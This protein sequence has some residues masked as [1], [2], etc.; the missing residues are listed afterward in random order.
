MQ[1]TGSGIYT[2]RLEADENQPLASTLAPQL[3]ATLLKMSN[4]AA[5]KGLAERA[6][7]SLAGFANALSLTYE[8]FELR[9][10]FAP[11]PGLAD[12]G[13]LE[14][15]LADLLETVGEAAKADQGCVVLG[16]D[17]FQY[18]NTGET[19]ALISALHRISRLSLPVILIAAGLPQIRGNVGIAKSY[20]ERLFEF[21][22]IGQLG[23][24]DA[25]SAIAKP[26]QNEGQ[27]IEPS[28]LID[29]VFQTQGYPYFLQE[30]GKHLWDVAQS[31][32]I[33]ASDVLTATEFAIDELD[34]GFFRVRYDQ[35]TNKERAYLRAMA[36]LGS[37]PHQSGAI[38]KAL[39]RSVSSLGPTRRSLIRKGMLWSP[40]HGVTAF[41]VPAFDDFMRRV[42][43]RADWQRQVGRR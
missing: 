2:V 1:A 12:S 38:A 17:E 35:L 39:G 16:I 13:S 37:G 30:W 6:L 31:F 33:D 14:S 4:R 43:S 40:G 36:D 7:R 19:A 23:P 22:E 20:A 41:A 3:R 32:P 42:I 11:E 9:T 34:R 21:I 5:A 26:L 27:Q 25:A 29:L 10:D 24:E 8:G 28:A 15:D 18:F